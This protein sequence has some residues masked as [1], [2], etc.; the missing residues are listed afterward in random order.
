M[1]ESWQAGGAEGRSDSQGTRSGLSSAAACATIVSRSGS[2]E[3]KVEGL[4]SYLQDITRI[5]TWRVLVQDQREWGGFGL[6]W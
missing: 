4:G 2:E 3:M 6:L 1:T 5:R